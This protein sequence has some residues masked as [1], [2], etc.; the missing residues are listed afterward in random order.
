MAHTRIKKYSILFV[1]TTSL[2]A[3][4]EREDKVGEQQKQ[5]PLMQ[6][7][8][9]KE[10]AYKALVNSKADL[11]ENFKNAGKGQEFGQE[12][13]IK[14]QSII[15]EDLRTTFLQ[16]VARQYY[17]RYSKYC[18]VGCEYGFSIA[19]LIEHGKITIDS[20]KDTMY[21]WNNYR[22]NSL[23][24]LQR[25]PCA[26]AITRL[27]LKKNIITT[28]PSH[29][30]FSFSHLNS[31]NMCDNI[32]EKIEDGA[33]IA[34]S[35][36]TSLSLIHNKLSKITEKTFTGL[37]ALNNLILSHN[38]I[39]VIESGALTHLAR[40]QVLNLAHNQLSTVPA[41]LYRLTG[42]HFLVLGYNPLNEDERA[43][44]EKALNRR[45]IRVTFAHKKNN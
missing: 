16:E 33:F 40:L 43:K 14:T 15:P 32:I 11:I 41:E 37:V 19:E 1:V 17:F 4:E 10:L 21:T 29:L 3:M 12:D 18:I 25:I 26:Q 20:T 2:H 35:R 45:I 31:I 24:G 9:F 36:L 38:E 23:E 39:D 42:V 5:K 28:I 44:I 8:S 6:V 34:L 27:N 30:L 7:P 13:L 22:I